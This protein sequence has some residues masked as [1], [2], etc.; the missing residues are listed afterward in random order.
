M[1][2]DYKYF[3]IAD[4][5]VYVFIGYPAWWLEAVGYPDGPPPVS[6]QRKNG[7]PTLDDVIQQSAKEVLVMGNE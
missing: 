2:S 5:Y 3:T 7:I 6:S 1:T 4:S